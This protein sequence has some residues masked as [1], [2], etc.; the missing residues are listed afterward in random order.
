[1]HKSISDWRGLHIDM[2]QEGLQRN[3]YVVFNIVFEAYY[4][5]ITTIFTFI[6]IIIIIII[7][8]FT[9]LINLFPYILIFK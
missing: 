2:M 9:I 8:M 7:I 6:I 1:M 3:L 5:F 4:Y